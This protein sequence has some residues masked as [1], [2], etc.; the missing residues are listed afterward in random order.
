MRIDKLMSLTTQ[1]MLVESAFNAVNV[2]RLFRQS[3]PAT[4]LGADARKRTLDDAQLDALHETLRQHAVALEARWEALVTGRV[5]APPQPAEQP[6]PPAG[7]PASLRSP[8]SASAGL[9][10]TTPPAPPGVAIPEGVSDAEL[11]A[12]GEAVGRMLRE[13][14]GRRYAQALNEQL[15]SPQPSTTMDA[16]LRNLHNCRS[17]SPDLV[18]IADYLLAIILFHVKCDIQTRPGAYAQKETSPRDVVMNFVREA[19]QMRCKLE[20]HIMQLNASAV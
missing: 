7:G 2:L 6:T 19:Y 11:A 9:P 10:T 15:A 4:E 18:R 13:T 14:V 1:M 20:Q 8:P 3:V 5:T 12:Q 16:N 17:V